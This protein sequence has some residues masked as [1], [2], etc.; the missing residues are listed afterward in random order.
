MS[1][2]QINIWRNSNTFCA[3]TNENFADELD[4]IKFNEFMF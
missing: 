4:V 2:R 3:E 1:K